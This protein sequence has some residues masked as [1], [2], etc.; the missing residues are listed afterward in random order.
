MNWTNAFGEEQKRIVT[1]PEEQK[2]IV[3]SPEEQQ[4]KLI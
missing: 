1:S 3:N 2:R 4:T